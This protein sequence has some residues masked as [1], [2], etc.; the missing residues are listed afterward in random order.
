MRKVKCLFQGHAAK[1][2]GSTGPELKTLHYYSMTFNNI[3]S[4]LAA[5][6]ALYLQLSL[7]GIQGQ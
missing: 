1:H 3:A 5:L 7:V 6:L 2:S 4:A